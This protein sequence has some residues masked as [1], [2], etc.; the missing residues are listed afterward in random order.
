MDDV[1][2][3]ADQRARSEILFRAVN[4]RV[5]E[6]NDRLNGT[7]DEL[8]MI[9]VCECGNT[10]CNAQITMARTEYEAL[11]ANPLHFA[12]LPG[13]EDTRIARVEE[14][15]QGFLVADKKGEAAEMA[16]EERSAR[17]V[18]TVPAPGA[19]RARRAGRAVEL[20]SVRLLRR[21]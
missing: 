3:S 7:S 1:D 18:I 12:V 6:F 21:S 10:D 5:E 13:H 20:V 8:A 16:I 2:A 11:R 14:Q 4:E 9:F 15:H 19:D 17:R